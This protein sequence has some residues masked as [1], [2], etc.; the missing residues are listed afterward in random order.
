[1][2]YKVTHDGI[3]KTYAMLRHTAWH[4]LDSAKTRQ[5]GSMLN[6][7]AAAV[8]F[9][10][11]F[12]AYL[13]HVGAEEIEIWE[14]IERIPH[15]KK[16]RIIAKHLKMPLDACQPPFKAIGELF[17]L[18]DMLAHGRTRAIDVEYETDQEP[19]HYSSWRIHEWEKLTPEQVEEYANS[20]REAAEIINRSRT[21]PDEDLWNQGIRGRKVELMDQGAANKRPNRTVAP[22]RRG[23]TSG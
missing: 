16:L 18:R 2:R 21:S 17:R 3:T 10:F 12:E 23:A 15:S 9:A 1:M 5:E 4:L 8:F 7:R 11:A 19:P 6:L 14:E 13:N 22:R 20:V